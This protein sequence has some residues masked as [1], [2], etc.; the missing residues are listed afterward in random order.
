MIWAQPS[1]FAEEDNEMQWKALKQEG[2]R[3]INLIYIYG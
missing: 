2:K 1:Q 3:W